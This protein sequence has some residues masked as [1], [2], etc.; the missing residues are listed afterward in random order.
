MCGIAGIFRFDGRPIDASALERM[1]ISTRHRGPDDE[2]LWSEGPVGFAHNRLAIID[3]SPAGHQPMRDAETGNIVVYNGEIYNFRELRRDL[4]SEGYAF[5][6][7][8]DTEVLLLAYRRWGAAC[9]ERFIGMFAFAIFDVS[10]RELF[11]ARDRLG[12]KPLYYFAEDRKS[13]V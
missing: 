11:L 13:V 7:Q 2:G 3:L 12:I 10:R 4:E 5:R 1:R 8:C 6:S 9:L